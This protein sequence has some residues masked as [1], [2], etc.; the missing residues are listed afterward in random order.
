MEIKISKKLENLPKVDYRK[1]KPLQGN[2]KALHKR[3]Y[4]KLLKS[5][6]EFGFIVPFF[7]WINNGE[8][9]ILDGHQR[10]RVFTQEKVEPFELPCVEIEAETEQ[11]AKKKLLVIASQYGRISVDGFQEY[12]YSAELD[13]EEIFS[14]VSFDAFPD[15]MF[16]EGFETNNKKNEEKIECPTCGTKVKSEKIKDAALD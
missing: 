12:L 14:S 9:Y 3:E 7:V 2:L 1:L 10:C 8:V 15:Y 11:E 16:E 4:D 6:K 13:E 5:M